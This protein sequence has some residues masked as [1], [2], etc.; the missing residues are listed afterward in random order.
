LDAVKKGQVCGGERKEGWGE[1][2][3]EG[4]IEE[5]GEGMIQK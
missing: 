4:I 2:E 3:N 1:H 5:T